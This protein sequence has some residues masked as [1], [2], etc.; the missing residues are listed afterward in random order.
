MSVW[1]DKNG[2]YH[3]AVQR[4]GARIHRKCPPA[5]TWR[6]AKQK[7]SELLQRFDAASSGKVLIADAIQH[8]L[9]TEVAHHKARKGTEGNAYALAGW[10]EGRTLAEACAV[11]ESYKRDNRGRLT[12]STIN[13]RLAVLRR[14]ANLAY[15][16]WG[17]LSE[18]IG[19]KIE[20]LPEN[21]HRIVFFTRDEL[22]HALRRIPQRNRRKAVLVAAFTGIRRGKVAALHRLQVQGDLIHMRTS[23][24]GPPLTVPVV[25]HIAFAL[26]RL[27][28]GV[29]PDTLTHDVSKAFPGKRFHDLRRTAGAFLLQAG[30]PI[31]MVSE[32]L[33]HSDI[34]ITKRIYAHFLVDHKRAA[35]AKLGRGIAPVLH[36]E[37]K[38]VSAK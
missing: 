24:G 7:E 10:I 2:R 29:H 1:K 25:H 36:P 38:V 37:K 26:K 12:G 31:E 16:R 27:P 9:Q 23:K 15:K 4:G 17:W 13:R 6:Q 22:A 8:W 21:Q 5:Y 34:R 19:Q 18:P 14:V 30:V 3:V 20:L 28:F 11:A 33:G 35:I 32:I